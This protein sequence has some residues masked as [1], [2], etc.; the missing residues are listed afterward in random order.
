M[1]TFLPHSSFSSCARVLDRQRLGKQRVEA[2]QIL[3]ALA[4]ETQGWQNHP[5]TLMWRGHEGKLCDYGVAICREWLSRG[6]KDTLLPE[7]EHRARRAPIA[8]FQRP[9]WL[10]PE[11]TSQYRALL[12]HKKPEHY[13]QFGWTEEPIERIDY[14]VPVA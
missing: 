1:Q 12:L 5:V 2:L 8:S 4:G 7:F 6:Y 3:R 13:S 14:P 9:P 11:I 10:T